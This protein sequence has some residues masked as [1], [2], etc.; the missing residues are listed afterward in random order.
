MEDKNYCMSSY[1]ALR[2]IEDQDKNFKNSI[3][4]N[5]TPL[6]DAQRKVCSTA[7]DIDFAIDEQFKN[8][9]KKYKKLGIMLS[10]GMDSA[11]VASYMTGSDAYTFR[12]LGGKFQKEELKKAE[13]YAKYYGLKL[14]Y[15]DIGWNTVISYLKPVMIAKGAPVHSIEPQILQAALQA[16]QDGV[17][18]ILVGESSDLIFGGMDG[19]L[20]KDWTFDEF[21]DRYTFTKP[22]DVLKDPKSMGYLFER[23]RLPNNMIDFEK[24]MDD[25]FS[26]ESSGSYSNAFAVAGL[27]YYDPYAH[28]KMGTK[29]DLY[30]VRHGEP[31]YLIRE[32]MAK[33]YPGM[34]VP[35]KT[36]MPRPVDEY[37]KN[38]CG[39]RRAE[40]K[41]GLDMSKFTGNQKWQL[42]CL[43]QYLNLV[44]PDT[45]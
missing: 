5:F 41:E 12:F 15:V 40:F 33:K 14:H 36:P 6:T 29:L 25:V 26:I 22:E 24:F 44:Y 10:G 19:L 2:Y 45:I 9:K 11:I 17:D 42:W 3:H 28:L 16:K 32:L 8:L 35:N 20:A 18:C 7:N 30:R 4:K 27:D 31:K 37:F 43:E 38:W 13:Y 21:V 1:L 34:Q 39:P 23:Y